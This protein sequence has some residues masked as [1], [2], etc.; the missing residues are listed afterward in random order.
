MLLSKF[1]KY[2]NLLV[3]TVYV[4]TSVYFSHVFFVVQLAR[5]IYVSVLVCGVQFVEFVGEM[6]IFP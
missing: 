6:R 5:Y 4:L 2:E 1:I 3:I